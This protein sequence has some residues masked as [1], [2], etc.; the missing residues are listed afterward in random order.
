MNTSNS[1]MKLAIVLLII[2]MVQ[3]VGAEDIETLKHQTYKG[4]TVTRVEPDGIV[5]T[6]NTG[7]VKIPFTELSEQYQKRFGYDAEKAKAFAEADAEAQRN[8]A[9]QLRLEL[10][11]AEEER[12]RIAQLN[13]A[14]LDA[15]KAQREMEAAKKREEQTKIEAF[16]K[17]RVWIGMTTAECIQSCSGPLQINKTLTAKGLE[18]QWVYPSGEEG[19]L[20]YL[21]FENGILTTIQL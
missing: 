4:A 1:K 18:E 12:A 13:Q 11:K 2:A 6:Y 15:A 16:A 21:Y 19:K 10:Q 7:I 8:L 9:A 17:H 3:L 5:L 20:S 14:D